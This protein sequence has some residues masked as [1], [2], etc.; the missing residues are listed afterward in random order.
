MAADVLV[1]GT[2]VTRAG[3]AVS[4]EDEISL[5]AAQRFVSRGG[6]K[7]DHALSTFGLDVRG[8]IAA[9][10]GASTGGF[11]DCLLQRGVARVY[12]IDVGY[13]Q[14]ASRLRADPRVV[15]IER[16]NVRH[17]RSLP[18]RVALV[19][20]DVSFIGLSLVLPTAR[21]LLDDGGRIVALVKPQFEAGRGEVGRGGVVRDPL[22]H[23][24]VLEKLFATAGERGLEV[25]GLTA[26]PLRG[27]AGNIE[28]LA[29]LAPGVSS[30][31]M[32]DA[33]ERTLAEV[34]PE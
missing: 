1:N 24:R 34:P 9:D 22:T 17:L 25:T 13:G 3:A 4:R 6:E 27:P 31:P 26:S 32:N 21:N 18:E 10:F 7:L 29:A 30:I 28:F 20:I 33:I 23:R 14:L 11:T 19:T 12:S 8:L 5:K 2:T 16:T 15:V